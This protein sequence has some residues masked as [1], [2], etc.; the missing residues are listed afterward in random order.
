MPWRNCLQKSPKMEFTTRFTG[1]TTFL[2][3]LA[4]RM[5]DPSGNGDGC[6]WLTCKEH[7]PD[8]YS[9]MVLSGKLNSYLADLNEQVQARLD[10]IVR[11]MA[12]TEE[13]VKELGEGVDR[14]YRDMAEAGLP[15]PE[16][17][18]AEFMLSATLKNKNWG[19]KETSWNQNEQQNGHENG[20]QNGH[21]N[22]HDH[23]TEL[24]RTLVA[25]C[26]V[27]RTRAEMMEHLGLSARSSFY[28]NYLKPLLASGMLVMTNPNNHK[29]KDQKY[30][31][32][33]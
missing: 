9:Q 28:E 13:F 24:Q 5:I 19:K 17:Q 6:T 26:A 22:G 21:E 3:L 15:E 2:I 4:R 8:L 30:I 18:Q 16:Y 10:L 31:A 11:R 29:S 12:A 33:K 20:H 7:K 14:V 23:L 1:T 25:F 32:K 27:P